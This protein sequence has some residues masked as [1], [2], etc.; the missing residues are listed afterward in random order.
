[1]RFIS[2]ASVD[3]DKPLEQLNDARSQ[4]HWAIANITLALACVVLAG[5]AFMYGYIVAGL[6]IL[7]GS[8]A[9]VVNAD[10]HRKRGDVF[11]REAEE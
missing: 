1:M 6:L 5:G 4:Y 2:M 3:P 7:A 11:A 9:L 10:A 8:V